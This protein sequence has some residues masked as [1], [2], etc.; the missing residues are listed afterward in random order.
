MDFSVIDAFTE[1]AFGGNPAAVVILKDPQFP[2]DALMQKIAREMNLAET[3]FVISKNTSNNKNSD[4]NTDKNEFQLR[5]FTPGAE[6]LLCGHATLAAAKDI[7]S[8]GIVSKEKPIYFS[9]KSGV[10][11]ATYE[12]ET[13]LISLNFPA[14]PSIPVNPPQ[15]LLP[16]L[17]LTEDEVKYIGKNRM[18]YLIQIDSELRLQQLNPNFFQLKK[19][20]TRTVIVTCKSEKVIESRGQKYHIDFA[21]RVFAPFVGIDEDPVTGSAHCCL[22]VYWDAILKKS[23]SFNA[24]QASSRGGFLQLEL[25]DNDQRV[26]LK[27]S[28]VIV[29]QGR[30][31]TLE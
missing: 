26:I 3:S 29:S 15:D 31:L 25:I 10:L 12:I 7:Y 13:D 30:F 4:D 22:A 19:V 18:D 27:G 14:E 21:S 5:W 2:P 16:S 17:G 28:A 20:E 24:Y 8:K 6:V 9:T 1:K 11:T 23:K